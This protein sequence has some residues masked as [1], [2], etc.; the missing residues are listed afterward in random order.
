MSVVLRLESFP[1]Y[2]DLFKEAE[3][4]LCDLVHEL[5]AKEKCADDSPRFQLF[6]AGF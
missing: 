4:L 5:L 3:H 6:R 1:D 2:V